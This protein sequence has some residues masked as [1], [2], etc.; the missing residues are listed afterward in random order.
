VW[1]CIW[2]S[3]WVCCLV[4]IWPGKEGV[5][6]LLV[7]EAEL[8]EALV[9]IDN[10]LFDVRVEFGRGA[11]KE[12]VE[13]CMGEGSVKVKAGAVGACCIFGGV[14]EVKVFSSRVIHVVCLVEFGGVKLCLFANG[15]GKDGFLVACSTCF[16]V[17]FCDAGGM[18]GRL[19]SLAG[20]SRSVCRNMVVDGWDVCS[21]GGFVQ[22]G[23]NGSMFGF[24]IAKD[25]VVFG[26]CHVGSFR[27]GG[28]GGW[29]GVCGCGEALCV[30]LQ[31]P[32]MGENL[33]EGGG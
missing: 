18:V 8:F 21:A 1:G 12:G 11:W 17:G 3:V 4:V 25:G 28:V 22:E 30:V 33:C 16:V 27:R 5:G 6:L 7:V 14:H 15:R 32:E 10:V 2:S 26:T 20:K 13:V 23:G 24:D 31:R 9:S 29:F 19:E